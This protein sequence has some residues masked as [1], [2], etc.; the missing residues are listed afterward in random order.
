MK[1]ILA[2]TWKVS[3]ED[4]TVHGITKLIEGL[5]VLNAISYTV[6]FSEVYK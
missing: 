5:T 6:Y 4:I 3:I 2:C 1:R